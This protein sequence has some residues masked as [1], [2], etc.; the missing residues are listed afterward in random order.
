[1]EDQGDGAVNARV[2]EFIREVANSGCTCRCYSGTKPAQDCKGFCVEGKARKLL[3]EIL[4]DDSTSSVS[5]EGPS[6]EVEALQV[7]LTEERKRMELLTELLG[8][9]LEF[10]CDQRDRAKS[11]LVK[12]VRET[13]TFPSKC[14]Q[15]NDNQPF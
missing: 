6:K 8:Q 11:A 15:T 12:I 7:E 3:A 4:T 1:M 2:F 9:C 14:P 5:D 10:L 13:L